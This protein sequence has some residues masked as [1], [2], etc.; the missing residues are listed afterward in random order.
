MGQKVH[1]LGFRLGITKEWPVRWFA[2]KSDYGNLFLE[3]EKI[4]NYLTQKLEPAGVKSIEIERSTNTLDITMEV[5]KPG[6]VIGRGGLGVETLEKELKKF[7]NSKIKITAKA[8]KVREIE[9]ALVAEYIS[10]QLLRRVNFRRAA[11][12]ALESA[13]NKG[14]KGIKIKL[15]GRLGGRMIARTERFDRGAVPLHTLRAD[16]DYAQVH[17]KTA[18]GLVGIKVWIYKGEIE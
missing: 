4:R 18:A 6:L 5:A 16:I 1:P 14:A 2:S 8:V 9:A 7:T 13:M 15:A 10:R 11:M 12:Y 3:D 17:C